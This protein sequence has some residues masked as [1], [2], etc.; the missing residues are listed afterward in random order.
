MQEA[1]TEIMPSM[2]VD[3]HSVHDTSDTRLS[4]PAVLRVLAR[5]SLPSLV[6]ATVIPSII[7]YVCLVMVGPSIAMLGVLSWTYGALLRRLAFR[8]QVPAVLMLAVLGLTVRTVLGVLSGTFIYFL[9]PVLT[10]LVLSGTFLG[11]FCL[12]RPIIGRIAKEFCP[13]SPEIANRPAV[14]R[15]FGGLTLLWAG[16]HLLTAAITFI[17]LMSLSTPD[18]VL[19]KTVVCLGI[20]ICAIVLTVS[21]S[22]QTAR[23]EH[24]VLAR[25]MR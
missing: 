4:K 24:L 21:W 12:G 10:T 23:S 14:L 15:L 17:L 11:S 25:V 18:F 20:T 1:A 16:V 5:R 6:E 2:L 13:L 22:I 8:Q 3:A 19:L 7:F 9:Q